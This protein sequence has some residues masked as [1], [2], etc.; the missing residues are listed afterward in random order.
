MPSNKIRDF[1]ASWAICWKT[2][3]SQCI[4]IPAYFIAL[5]E[6]RLSN[7]IGPYHLTGHGIGALLWNTF[8]RHWITDQPYLHANFSRYRRIDELG[9]D[10]SSIEQDLNTM[11][12]D[13]FYELQRLVICQN[14]AGSST[15]NMRR[16]SLEG[17]SEGL[18][19]D[20]IYQSKKRN[21]QQPI[22]RREAIIDVDEFSLKIKGQ[23]PI[24]DDWLT[25]RQPVILPTYS[26]LTCPID[27]MDFFYQ[28][29]YRETDADSSS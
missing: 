25:P 8:F 4:T 23:P 29:M 27:H 12:K 17:L 2:S 5:S 28:Y 3:A 10:S 15:V 24:P 22:S 13:Q 19:L 26:G 18:V 6:A 20:S 7:G 11:T 21:Y 1:L 9:G 16:T 14:T